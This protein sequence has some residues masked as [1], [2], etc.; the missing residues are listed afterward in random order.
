MSSK[1][2]QRD[3]SDS[4]GYLFL[5]YL[6]VSS[7]Y[8]GTLFGCRVQDLMQN[9]MLIKHLLAFFALYFTISLFDKDSEEKSPLT[10]L[11]NSFGIYILFLLSTK[12]TYTTWVLYL[13]LLA[14]IYVISIFQRTPG[15]IKPEYEEKV[16]KIQKLL[17]AGSLGVLIFGFLLYYGEKKL[18]FQ[19]DFDIYKFISGNPKCRGVT[20]V[21]PSSI[22]RLRAAFNI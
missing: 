20:N 14:T 15:W 16:R 17:I 7:N 19:K 1:D 12:M 3:W 11:K 6:M 2:K 10:K 4:L 9:N 13:F 21:K 8:M 5:L 22:N 18:E